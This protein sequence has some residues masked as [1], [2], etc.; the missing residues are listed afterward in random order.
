M[1]E[2]PQFRGDYILSKNK[3]TGQLISEKNILI[4]ESADRPLAYRIPA[5]DRR[6]SGRLPPQ[7]ASSYV[8]DKIV[9]IYEA[10]HYQI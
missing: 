4:N 7:N 9:L 10:F 8:M 5:V 3:E 1:G 2:A 6:T